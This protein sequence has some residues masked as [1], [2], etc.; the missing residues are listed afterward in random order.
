MY[1]RKIFYLDD[2]RQGNRVG[3]AGYARVCLS[4]REF[5]L[6]I[7]IKGLGLVGRREATVCL[8]KGA[9]S[10]DLA[11]LHLDGEKGVLQGNYPAAQVAGSQWELL[12]FDYLRIK[13][14]ESRVLETKLLFGVHRE[15]ESELLV[16]QK[17]PPTEAQR[18]GKSEENFQKFEKIEKSE[19]QTRVS[20]QGREPVAQN[21]QK[22][23]ADF[24]SDKWEQ[25]CH[26]YPHVHPFRDKLYLS[27]TPGD[28]VIF[29][30]EYQELVNNSFLLH[31]FYNYR[32]LILGQEQDQGKTVYYLGVP[33]N[34]Y[35]REKSVAVLFG[36]EGFEASENGKVGQE[37]VLNWKPGTFGY[38]MKRVEI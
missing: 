18:K 34:Y 6:E 27:L 37:P 2:M 24:S 36:F 1:L 26:T 25:L 5:S 19:N 4:G 14:S 31:G 22:L 21:A 33:G 28:F 20:A 29:R 16:A 38:Y 3:N 10:Y 23:L 17:E 30:K 9:R 32:H 8:E 12:D 35:D 11:R 15:P 13:V 7:R